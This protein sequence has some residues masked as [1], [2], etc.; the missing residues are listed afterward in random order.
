VLKAEQEIIMSIAGISAI[1]SAAY[2]QQAQ[3]STQTNAPAQTAPAPTAAA[4]HSASVQQAAPNQSSGQ[5]RHHHHH[6]G[7]GSAPAQSADITQSGTTDAASIL[8]TLV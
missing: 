7:G 5:V 6:H 2:L 8:N 1:S 3:A 4:P